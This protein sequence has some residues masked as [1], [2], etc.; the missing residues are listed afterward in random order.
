[1]MMAVMMA[2]A[3]SASAMNIS[4][5][6]REALFL[7]DKMAYELGLN[8]AQYEAVYKINFDYLLAVDR[9][10]DL[11]GAYWRNRNSDLA[12]VLTAAQYGMMSRTS[13]F[14]RP[15]SWK[16]GAWNFSIYTVYVNPDRYY[17]SAPSVY[18]SYRGGNDRNYYASRD[19]GNGRAR[20]VQMVNR[21]VAT[22]NHSNLQASNVNFG[23]GS[24]KAQATRQFGGSANGA[25]TRAVASNGS[26]GGNKA[27]RQ[28][29]VP[30][31]SNTAGQ[32]SGGHFGNR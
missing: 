27:Q 23:N 2:A 1:M 21:S 16:S 19:F 26:F 6:R 28:F 17:R 24:R 3:V 18:Y 30:G 22:T 9:V 13:Y 10:S 25:G 29:Q 20:N 14:Y 5:A 12:Y 7:T 11:Y 8:D 31:R 4:D 32:S 15:L